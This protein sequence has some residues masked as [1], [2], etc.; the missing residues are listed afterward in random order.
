ML[1]G[2]NFFYQYVILF[3]LILKLENIKSNMLNSDSI[4]FSLAFQNIVTEPNKKSLTELY[5]LK[6][7]THVSAG[8]LNNAGQ[9]HWPVRTKD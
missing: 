3:K 8:R 5:S 7:L 1:D 4:S 6:K 9:V 2:I